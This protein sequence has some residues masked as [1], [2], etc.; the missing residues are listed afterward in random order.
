MMDWVETGT[1]ARAILT[2]SAGQN[3]DLGRPT[4]PGRPRRAAAADGAAGDATARDDPAGLSLSDLAV[5]RRR[6]PTDAANWTKGRARASRVAARLARADLS[7]MPGGPTGPRQE[8]LP[9][10]PVHDTAGGP[11][12]RR[13]SS[14]SIPKSAGAGP[15]A[16]RLAIAGPRGSCV[17]AGRMMGWILIG[18]DTALPAI[19]RYIWDCRRVPAPR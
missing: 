13:S 6:S 10:T 7:P 3:P 9:P 5:I 12:I 4:S 1:C 11:K 18:D 15:Y 19:G 8:S 16:A 17:I 2:F 14:G